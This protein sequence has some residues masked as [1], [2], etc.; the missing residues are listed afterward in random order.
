MKQKRARI[1]YYN[2]A[3]YDGS[4]QIVLLILAKTVYTMTTISITQQRL[5]QSSVYHL[6]EEFLNCKETTGWNSFEIDLPYEEISRDKFIYQHY[7]YKAMAAIAVLWILS[8]ANILG[9]VEGAYS[10]L[11]LPVFLGSSIGLYVLYHQGQAVIRLGQGSDYDLLFF[12][13]DD[14]R[15]EAEAFVAALLE[16]QR[17]FLIEKYWNCVENVEEKLDYLEW[18]K[19][20][21]VIDLDTFKVMRETVGY[22]STSSVF[23][24]GFHKE[25]RA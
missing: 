14:H 15:E 1:V 22:R 9:I 25:E 20:R 3:A 8:L 10:L 19:N 12:C 18:L 4:Q 16:K 24:I 6:E 7:S 17:V 11:A 5:W 13:D 21:N 2:R 23:P